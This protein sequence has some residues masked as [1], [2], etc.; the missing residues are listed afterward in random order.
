LGSATEALNLSWFERKHGPVTRRGEVVTHANGWAAVTLDGWSEQ[1]ACPVEAKH[2]GGREPLETIIDRYAAQRHWAAWVTGTNRCAFSVIMGAN[3]PIVE[4]IDSDADYMTELYHRAEAF[5]ACVWELRPPVALTPVAAPVI[6]VKVYEMTGNN[7][8]SSNAADWLANKAA[9]DIAVKAE[10]ELKQ[11]VPADAVR[12]HG[13]QVVI[14]R[15]RA[16]R[17]TLKEGM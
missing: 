14:K 1:Y 8:W 15:D 2:T 5:M 3:E 7:A 16:G 12:C 9:R 10:K 4:I 17:L 13:H 6:P 11:L